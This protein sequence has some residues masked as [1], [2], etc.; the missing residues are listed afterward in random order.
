MELTNC[1]GYNG[2]NFRTTSHFQD[3]FVCG[4]NLAY[5][6]RGLPYTEKKEPPTGGNGNA[7]HRL[8]MKMVLI[9]SKTEHKPRVVR[10]VLQSVRTPRR[11]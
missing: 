3:F 4:L 1:D 5:V 9:L 7:N 6:H 10:L 8:Q 2:L 11:M